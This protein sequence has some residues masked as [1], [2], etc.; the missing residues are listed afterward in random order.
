M[1][2]Y[3]YII[4]MQRLFYVVSRWLEEDGSKQAERISQMIRSD[5]EAVGFRY[6]DIAANERQR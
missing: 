2:D 5:M 6:E 4:H 3:N 1:L